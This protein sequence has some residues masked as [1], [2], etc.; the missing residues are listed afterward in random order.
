MKSPSR[1]PSGV[2][3]IALA[4]FVLAFAVRFNW[5]LHVQSPLD[6]EYSDMGGYAS[7]ADALL[8]HVTPGDP[9]LL[10]TYP[11]GTHA[12]LA[13]EFLVLGR[14]ATRAIAVAHALVGSIPAACAPYLVVRLLP[15][16]WAAA[17]VGLVVALWYP[18]VCFT[19]FFLSEIWFSALVA[20]H[21]CLVAYGD[22]TW[23]VG[24]VGRQLT[25]GL[26]SG[27]A[28]VV[29]PQFLLTWALDLAGRTLALLHRR[30]PLRTLGVVACLVAPMALA[31]G[32][33]A[34][35]LHALSGHWGLIAESGVNRLWAD[36]D[37]CKIEAKWDMPDGQHYEYWFSPPSKQPCDAKGTV[38]FT[39]FVADGTILDRI[40]LK[41]LKGVS[42][43][44]RLTRMASN[45]DLLI[46]RNR[47]WPESNYR[48]QRWRAGLQDGFAQALKLV[49]L[50]LCIL[51]LLLG[52]ANATTRILAA[53]LLT[54][55]V[56]S[57]VFFGE[58]RY[59]VPY[60]PFAIVLAVVGAHE[61]VR[62]GAHGIAKLRYGRTKRAVGAA[63]AHGAS[64]PPVAE[65]GR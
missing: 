49:V 55:V 33:S 21:A 64:R 54:V 31:I 62:R 35:R 7:R 4:A 23:R 19:G 3:V 10:T 37:I 5:V 45:A 11:Y 57:A 32:A 50:P 24:R 61:V 47:P 14:H 60:D 30:G 38:H 56:A 20:L 42:A 43:W 39:G 48:D 44:S 36:T 29:R 25:T 40:R 53:N 41:R 6:A 1:V 13:L 63:L 27:L 51:G 17:L 46:D 65:L 15:R 52:P 8:A 58:A 34:V 26:V 28:F 22:G 16:A 2:T 12:I 9:R 59:H 18:Q